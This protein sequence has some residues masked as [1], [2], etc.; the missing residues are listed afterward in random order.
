M[1]QHKRTL[2]FSFLLSPLALLWTTPSFP[3]YDKTHC[4][5]NEAALKALPSDFPSFL[6]EEQS[7]I[8]YQGRE[9]DRWKSKYAQTLKKDSSPE[10][11]LNIESIRV[12]KFPRD[13]FSYMRSLPKEDPPEEVGLLPFA[14]METYQKLFLSFMEWRKNSPEEERKAIERNITYY[15][16]LL[17]HYVADG[18]TPLHLTIH[19]DG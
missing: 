5:I 17:G 9:P 13:R 6:K 10:H 1:I 3:W 19:H 8:V 18:S 4:L 16:G 11:W 12:S 15:A 14:I 2:S 7:C